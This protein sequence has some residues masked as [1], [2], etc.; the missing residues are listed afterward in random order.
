MFEFEPFAFGSLVLSTAEYVTFRRTLI[1][2]V[3]AEMDAPWNQVTYDS[4]DEGGGVVRIRVPHTPCEVV[5]NLM[6]W[7]ASLGE[8]L[9]DVQLNNVRLEGN[10]GTKACPIKADKLNTTTTTATT[11]TTTPT[12]LILAPTDSPVAAILWINEKTSGM[13]RWLIVA[14]GAGLA[15]AL[16]AVVGIQCGWNQYAVCMGTGALCVVA[17]GAAMIVM[18]VQGNLFADWCKPK[19]AICVV[20]G[21]IAGVICLLIKLLH[22][23]CSRKRSDSADLE[24]YK[25]GFE[26]EDVALSPP[27]KAKFVKAAWHR[28]DAFS[29]T[30]TDASP[31]GIVSNE[32]WL[33]AS[34]DGPNPKIM[35]AVVNVE[36]GKG[37]GIGVGNEAGFNYV[38]GMKPGGNAE[39]CG[40]IQA[41]DRIKTINKTNVSKLSRE[42]CIAQL[43][44]ASASGKV[45]LGLNR[46]ATG[47]PGNLPSVERHASP[48]PAVEET[49][50]GA[51]TT[52]TSAGGKKQKQIKKDVLAKIAYGSVRPKPGDPNDDDLEA[53]VL[54]VRLLN[55]GDGFGMSFVGPSGK[56]LDRKRGVFI[57]GTK[58]GGA[59]QLTGEL[60][61]GQRVNSINGRD[62]QNATRKVVATMFKGQS[63]VVLEVVDDWSGFKQ[64]EAET[65]K[66]EKG[67]QKPLE[68]T[69]LPVMHVVREETVILKDIVGANE[70]V[71]AKIAVPEGQGLGIGIVNENHAN[72][73]SGM[74]AGGNLDKSGL[75]GVGDRLLKVNNVDV[76]SASREDC[77]GALK[78]ATLRSFEV[79]LVLERP[80][81]N[82]ME[83]K[84][85]HLAQTKQQPRFKTITVEVNVPTGEG[86]GV[87]IQNV[88]NKNLIT[89]TKPGGNADRAGQFPLRKIEAGDR[90]MKVN[91]ISVAKVSREECIAA[92]KAATHASEKVFLT[93]RREAE[94]AKDASRASAAAGG[95]ATKPKSAPAL[96]PLTTPPG[97]TP[98]TQQ[99]EVSMVVPPGEGIGIGVGNDEGFNYVHSM[100]QGGNA[101]RTG[102]IQPGDRFFL[103]NKKVV[104][105]LPREECIAALKEA[106]Q[107]GLQMTIV[108]ERKT[109]EMQTEKAQNNIYDAGGPPL[110]KQHDGQSNIYDVGVP[111]KRAAGTKLVDVQFSIPP[112]TGV[113]VS[114]KKVAEGIMLSNLS[115]GGNAQKS[116]LLEIGDIFMKVNDQ[117]VEKSSKAGVVAALKATV[118]AGSTV[119][120][121]V[122]RSKARAT[123]PSGGSVDLAGGAPVASKAGPKGAGA[124][125]KKKA[126][127][128]AGASTIQKTIK[129]KVVVD[130]PAGEG[131]GIG[132]V[133]NKGNNQV[134]GMQPGGNA[135][136][137]GL[138]EAGD[139]FVSINGTNVA[140]ASREDCIAA[141]KAATQAGTKVELVFRRA[142]SMVQENKV[143]QRVEAIVTVPRGEGIG[144]GVVND[145][146][147]NAVSGMKPGGNAHKCGAIQPGDVFKFVNTTDVSNCS[148]EDCIAALKAGTSA[149]NTIKLIFERPN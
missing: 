72:Y 148:R 118:A 26:M 62:V 149:S 36:N 94:P 126:K 23:C 56:P 102:S 134:K 104:Q 87:G 130:V 50:F 141:L 144:I 127:K 38:R 82:T 12:I 43:K 76:S 85:E 89:G 117:D 133:H 136:R 1:R 8:N 47:D 135:D 33:D 29:F 70:T 115:P 119:H 6:R 20:I 41:G 77:I 83:S 64:Y 122:R 112:G 48:A 98:G 3:A 125:N 138:I 120:L 74:K 139:K 147:T 52:T 7:A 40:S 124:A 14:I 58:D 140:K 34:D 75:V 69:N 37:L 131:F 4:I 110:K 55:K 108:F 106:A 18:V 35:T 10:A 32:F 123:G 2:M 79:T 78:A 46:P 54:T 11:T 59:A 66:K 145:G 13:P 44:H 80:A 16:V 129:V 25:A 22:H 73:I 143:G 90:I 86:L 49:T 17:G 24:D 116:G 9:G 109:V 19:W 30:S 68:D 61:K 84:V 51:T 97:Q 67:P 21:C 142:K 57:S 39:Q 101:D 113:G 27:K 91:S 81:G 132:I 93:L 95:G 15:V 107:A 114:L 60:R 100:K 92:L 42:K 65:N 53:V 71:E 111:P 105:R 45:T 103:I 31:A 63:D 99:V 137:C 128:A 5:Q 146:S 121:V 88:K 28:A 96:S